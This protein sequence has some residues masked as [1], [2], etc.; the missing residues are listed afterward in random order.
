M[1]DTV[2]VVVGVLAALL[3]LGGLAGLVAGAWADGLWAAVTGAVVLVA[4]TLERTRYRSE[5][6]ERSSGSQPGLGGGEPTVPVAPFRP[7]DELFVDPTSGQRLR[8]YLNPATG[9]RRY[10]AEEAR[11]R[12]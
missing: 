12:G 9:E 10:Y 3:M 5:A 8:V 11:P 4:V 2:R 1:V 7:T 6:A